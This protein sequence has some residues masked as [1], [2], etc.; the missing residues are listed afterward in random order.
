MCVERNALRTMYWQTLQVYFMGG[1]SIICD[2]GH[3]D[4]VHASAEPVCGAVMGTLVCRF[5]CTAGYGRI[6][7]LILLQKMPG[8]N[9]FPQ[10]SL[11]CCSVLGAVILPYPVLLLSYVPIQLQRRPSRDNV[12]TAEVA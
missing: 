11:L 4:M 3:S 10:T 7:T 6:T 9:C 2:D 12:C 8:V 5:H 1:D